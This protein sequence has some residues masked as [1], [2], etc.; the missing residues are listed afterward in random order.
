MILKSYETNKINLNE[1]KLIL[2][3]GKN[4]GLKNEVIKN[5]TKDESNILKYDEKEILENSENFISNISSQSLFEKEKFI[6]IKR[7]SDK[8]FAIIK[9]IYERKVDD[10]KIIINAEILDKK[11]K[12]RSFFDKDKKLIS[13]AFYPDN[14]QILSKLAHNFLQ[15]K[16]IFISYANINLIISKTGNDRELLFNELE[17]IVLYS[18][19]KKKVS[20]EEIAK[21]TNLIENHS[22]SDL[23]DNCLI[24]NK[25]KTLKILNENNFTS[26]EC[27]LITRTF[28]HKIKRI[29]IL[30]NNFYNSNN[31]ELTISSAKPPIFW[32]DKEIIKQQIIEWKPENIRKLIY[33]LND[34]ELQIKKNFNNSI[35]LIT[36]FIIEQC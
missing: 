16:N 12:L 15:D 26:E 17:K 9:E 35:N 1:N 4:E 28:L 10:V 29:L 22:I 13:V 8:I 20:S 7:S 19:N 23:I 24:K 14:E 21:L 31:M 36:N 3:H 32:K 34:I 27:I 33:K 6:I 5:L 18:A 25:K 11:S 2:L 30:S